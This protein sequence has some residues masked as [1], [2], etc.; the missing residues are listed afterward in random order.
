MPLQEDNQ[1]IWIVIVAGIFLIAYQVLGGVKSQQAKKFK[2]LKKELQAQEGDSNLAGDS[3][4]SSD[5][6][7]DDISSLEVS[8]K[9][10]EKKSKY[11]ATATDSTRSDYINNADLKQNSRESDLINQNIDHQ[12]LAKMVEEKLDSAQ[13]SNVK[14]QEDDAHSNFARQSS[15]IS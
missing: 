4:D 10:M 1:Y 9:R 2:K 7:D 12:Q 14:R 8:I 3:D 13:N 6:S 11:N 5:S 15:F